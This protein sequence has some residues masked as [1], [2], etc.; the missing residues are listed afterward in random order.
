MNPLRTLGGLNPSGC[1]F[2]H[3]RCTFREKREEGRGKRKR[4]EGI[5]RGERR[6]EEERG[7]RRE[8]R[9]EK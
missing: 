5:G 3:F 8:V 1:P 9:S 2:A 7:E 6:D 4:E